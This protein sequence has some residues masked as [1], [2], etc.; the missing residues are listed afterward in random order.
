MRKLVTTFFL[1]YGIFYASSQGI[2]ELIEA[3][4]YNL[5]KNHL[6]KALEGFQY[7]VEER[8]EELSATELANIYNNLGYLNL[9]LLNPEKA[10]EYLNFS[11]IYHEEAGNPN[12]TDYSRT[13]FNLARLHKDLGDYETALGY[14]ERA[15]GILENNNASESE[16]ALARVQ[17]GLLYEEAGHYDLALDIFQKSHAVII[18]SQSN[19]LTPE[20]AEV[21]SHM[22]RILIRNG[23]PK[24]AEQF[25]NQST[26]IYKQLGPDYD[27]ERAESLEDLGI[28]YER[29]GR[30]KEAESILLQALSLKESIPDEAD[31]LIIESINDLGVL[32]YNY[33]NYSKA[34]SMFLDVIDRCKTS[35]TVGTEHQF[36]ATALNNL[37]T[38]AIYEQDYLRARYYLR[39][40]LSIYESKYGK[41]HPYY[42]NILNNLARVERAEGNIRKAEEYYRE[43]LEIDQ[44]IYGR[45]HPDFATTLMNLGV[46]Y[47]ASGR[48]E[49]AVGYYQEALEIRKTVL[50]EDHPEY[51]NSLERL[52]LHALSTGNF[53]KAENYFRKAIE[54]E[55]KQIDLS[56][57][58]MTE[59]EREAF[60]RS[61][62]D[63]LDRYNFIAMELLDEKPELLKNIFDF[64]LK[65]KAILFNTATK[66]KNQVL[67]SGDA[68][69]QNLYKEW[70]SQK[71]LLA[72]YYQ[73]GAKDRQDHG[74]RLSTVENRVESLEKELVLKVEGFEKSI[75]NQDQNWKTVQSKVKDGEAIV[76][77]VRV[78]EFKSARVENSTI[79]GFT[80]F[81]QYL[82]IIFT[83]NKPEPSYAILGGN[84]RPDEQ[85][86]SQYRNAILY[87]VSQTDTYDLFWQP[88][89]EKLNGVKKVIVSPDG[90][91]FKMNLNAI[92]VPGGKYLIDKYFVEYIS[93]CNDLFE[94]SLTTKS[95]KAYFFGNP[96]YG[97]SSHGF[98]L[99]AL[100][101]AEKEVESVSRILENNGWSSIKYLNENASELRLRSAFRPQILHIATHGF[102]G[103]EGN[104]LASL[105]PIDN[106]LFKSGL[107]LS[108]V[109]R[110]YDYLLEG[111]PTT[112][113]NDGILTAYEAMNLE[114]DQTELVILSACES[115]LGKIEN[116]EGVYGL[117]RAFMVAGAKNIITSFIKVEDAATSELM[118]NFYEKFATTNQ[119]D[120][121]MHYAQLKLKEKYQDPKVWGAFI[122]TGKG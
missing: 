58:V 85:H 26:D 22:G 77:M 115:G 30:F 9:V 108:G 56:F 99:K 47:S 89:E 8:K 72:N 12:P 121:A 52:G 94:E 107:Y 113:S 96:A 41:N 119:V 28:F 23:N 27:V 33:S 5:D 32:Y 45:E 39:E 112:P 76:E 50:G 14:I 104:F 17:L 71:R 40:S 51:G 73:M 48:E 98:F 35:T 42:A 65:T 64:Q 46:L 29:I 91:F 43:C 80:D 67:N 3:A 100:G 18:N 61:V 2:N 93:S 4:E 59:T 74:I 105:S 84:F 87:Q 70:L 38:I 75:T 103:E 109:S 25:I 120:E 122:L 53:E 63:G 79:F 16:I 92:E 102:F 95:E 83:P 117:Q 82:A 114:L 24:E 19:M 1:C 31:V 62:K 86:Y 68:E 13:L 36:Y 106:P 7:L 88:V 81:T 34:K 55:I 11:T 10:A 6:E 116:G 21:C 54:I 49:E 111:I 60:Y 69:V 57:P 66:I 90:I 97:G 37:A 15:I 20:F 101:G 44:K 78:R 118:I 110:S